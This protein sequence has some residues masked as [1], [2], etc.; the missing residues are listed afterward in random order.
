MIRRKERKCKSSSS[1]GR[2]F[3]AVREE[4]ASH[5][6]D[7]GDCQLILTRGEH[8]QLRQESSSHLVNV[9]Q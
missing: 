2:L 6:T 3:I 4:G 1:R 7:Q 8:D 9:L 5:L